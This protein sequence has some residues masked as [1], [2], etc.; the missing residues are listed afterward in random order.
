MLEAYFELTDLYRFRKQDAKAVDLLEKL[1]A[2]KP[3]EHRPRFVLA[4]IYFTEKLPGRGANSVWTAPFFISTP[5][6]PFSPLT[7]NRC[8]S[9]ATSMRLWVTT[10]R[11]K[12]RGTG[13]CRPKRMKLI[14]LSAPVRYNEP[15]SP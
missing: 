14:D 6:W 9:W 11:L 8:A 15:R 5:L 10:W 13:P 7:A 2:M 12:R 3:D 4:S 1:A